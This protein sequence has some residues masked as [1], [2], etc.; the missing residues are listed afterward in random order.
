MPERFDPAIVNVGSIADEL[1]VLAKRWS[2][3][4]AR[5]PK[6]N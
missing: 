5:R 6:S 1:T 2:R 4:P 3:K